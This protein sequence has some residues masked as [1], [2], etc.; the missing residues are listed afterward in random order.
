MPTFH[1]K[2]VATGVVL[3]EKKATPK[4]GGGLVFGCRSR[5]NTRGVAFRGRHVIEPCQIM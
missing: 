3:V 5:N 4:P 1:T 2:S